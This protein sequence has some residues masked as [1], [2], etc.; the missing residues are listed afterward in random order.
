MYM[1]DVFFQ[2]FC[3]F[4]NFQDKKRKKKKEW[5]VKLEGILCRPVG[6]EVGL[7][8]GWQVQRGG[9]SEGIAF[10]MWFVY[11]GLPWVFTAVV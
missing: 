6:R 5:A 9:G 8:W 3:K 1:F 11:L 2:L 10:V 4:E 7:K